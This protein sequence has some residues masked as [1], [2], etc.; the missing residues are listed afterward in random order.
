MSIAARVY[1][2]RRKHFQQRN[3]Q[4]FLRNTNVHLI[5]QLLTLL[6]N[7]NSENNKKITL[8]LSRIDVIL[9]FY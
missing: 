3:A 9:L 2:E 5:T 6:L 7:L 1:T 4:R 8:T